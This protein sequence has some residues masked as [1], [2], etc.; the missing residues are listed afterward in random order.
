MTHSPKHHERLQQIAAL[1]DQLAVLIQQLH[2]HMARHAFFKGFAMDP[3]NFCKK[4][5]ASQQRDL[6]IILGE[7]GEMSG[8]M[9]FEKGGADGVWGSD[10]VRAAVQDMLSK[11]KK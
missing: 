9:E 2:H 10:A 8:S 3:V 11:P 7:R 5:L 1:D 6:E 4:W